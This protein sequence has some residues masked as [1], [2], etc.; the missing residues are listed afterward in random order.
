MRAAL[1]IA[2]RAAALLL[3]GLPGAG[4]AQDGTATGGFVNAQPDAPVE[5]TADRLD[6]ARAEGTALFTGSVV[7]IQGDMRLTADWV[8]VEYTR[9]A[10]GTLGEEIETITARV[11]VLLVT[12]EE[13]AEGDEAV[14]TPLS[15]SVLMTGNVLLTQGGNTVAGD[16]LIVDLETGLGEVQGRVRTVL[17]PATAGE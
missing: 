17:Q 2:A 6:L 12:P 7:A 11:N 9:A 1:T 16:R 13:A 15:N 4:I 10:D 14:Y 8:L 3:A 5:V